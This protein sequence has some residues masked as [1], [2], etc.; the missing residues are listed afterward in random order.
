M[1]I[2]RKQFEWRPSIRHVKISC[3]ILMILLFT[4]I[5]NCARLFVIESITHYK[6]ANYIAPYE[7]I[8]SGANTNAIFKQLKC[9]FSIRQIKRR[10]KILM[11]HLFTSIYTLLHLWLGTQ[12][13]TNCHLACAPDRLLG[14][15]ALAALFCRV[16]VSL[17]CC[18]AE[19][20]LHCL[21]SICNLV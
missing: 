3:K 5:Y 11:S 17:V 19:L 9:R 21:P 7:P 8:S 12:H 10:F 13:K 4:N 6:T 20:F 16:F 1:N 14:L 18:M 15:F 2:I